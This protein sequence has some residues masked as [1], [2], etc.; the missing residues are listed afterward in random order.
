[1]AMSLGRGISLPQAPKFS[2][3]GSA[4]GHG[5]QNAN[6]MSALLSAANKPPELDELKYQNYATPEELAYLGDLN[7]ENMSPT[8]L[9]NIITD[10]RLKEAQYQSLGQLDEQINN[11]GMTAIDRAQMQEIQQQQQSTDKGQR[12]AIIQQMAMKGLRG[13]GSE[14]AQQLQGQQSSAN[15]AAMQSAQVAANAQQA[16]QQAGLQRA[17]MGANMEGA[18][19]GRQAEQAG[20]QDL[21]NKFNVSNRN[22][23]TE[24]NVET[25]QNLA[26][27][28]TGNRNTVSQQN[29]GL[30]NDALRYNK[31]ERPQA[32]YGMTSAN[33]AAINQGITGA[34]QAQQNQ[35]MAQYQSNV[36]LAGAAL[37]AGGSMAGGGLASGRF[38][39]GSRSIPDSQY[40]TSDERL[41]EDIRPADIEIEA[42]LKELVPS[43]FRYKKETGLPQRE[44]VGIMAQDLEKSEVGN[45][46][47]RESDEGKKVDLLDAIPKI[48]ASLGHINNKVE[49]MRHGR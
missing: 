46:L 1:M 20:A 26:N 21:I 4:G 9:R 5:A 39:G 34:G 41:K 48:L 22:A 23:A 40:G 19:F 38:G 16:R 14:L 45:S 17:A 28:N 47:V 15:T 29:T 42:F 32:Q 31:V 7:I 49:G 25:R 8:E 44:Q 3:F 12:D 33:T 43:S 6:L 18:E 10:P 37:G 30:A 35:Q 24:R 36:G 27:Q 11:G 13:S 2:P